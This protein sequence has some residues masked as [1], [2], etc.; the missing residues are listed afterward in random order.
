MDTLP[1]SVTKCPEENKEERVY[2]GSQFR[3]TVHHGGE[4]LVAEFEV[5]GHSLCCQEADRN[6][7]LTSLSPFF[8]SL[9][10]SHGIVLLTGGR[11]S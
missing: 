10:T 11:T 3:D 1:F 4:V 6:S 8:F 7:L 5:A 2:F 9:E